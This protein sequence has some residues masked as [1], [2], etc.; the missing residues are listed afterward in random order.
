MS[1]D[2]EGPEHYGVCSNYLANKA[3]ND[4]IYLF[5]RSAPSFHISLTAEVP[6][7]LIGP[8]T[9][10]APFRGFW[11]HWDE[12]KLAG[13]QTPKVYLFFGCRTKGVDLYCDEKEDMLQ[14]GIL[15]KVFLALSRE[16]HVPKVSNEWR[17]N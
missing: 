11:Q 16:T 13:K 8:G 15:T 1:L 12:M 7:I 3:A 4:N 2:G 5:V 10:I 17:E 6:V 14:K 9:G